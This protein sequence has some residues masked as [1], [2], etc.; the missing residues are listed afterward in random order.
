MFSLENVMLSIDSFPLK[1]HTILFTTAALLLSLFLVHYFSRTKIQL[2]FSNEKFQTLINS[3]P[4]LKSG[5]F[6]SF[7]PLAF[8]LGQCYLAGK[9]YEDDSK[10]SH[11]RESFPYPN[12]GKGSVEWITDK[13]KTTEFNS[14]IIAFIIPGLCSKSDAPYLQDLYA[15]L[16]NNNIRPVVFIPRLN[17]DK[18]LLPNS[19]FVNLLDDI[20]CGVQYVTTKHPNAKLIGIGHS[21]GANCIVNYLAAYN[22]EK[23]IVA[24]ISIANPYDFVG[25]CWRIRGTIIEKYIMSGIKELVCKNLDE[26]ARGCS[27]YKTSMQDIINTT[28]VKE[29]DDAFTSK[30]MGY[31]D[32]MDYYTNISSDKSVWDVQVPLMSINAE[33]DPFIYHKGVPISAHEKNDNL[34]FVVTRKGGHLGWIEGIF[35]LRRWYLPIVV[36]Y[37]HWI[38]KSI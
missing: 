25:S 30:A 20:H 5:K 27:L 13:T 10:L 24:G 4:S 23:T 3:S 36:D 31:K 8:G 2:L 1:A 17:D 11:T 19:S 34:L 18:F 22:K 29:F 26:I 32:A 6:Y 38:S 15:R 14:N 21:Y 28:K 12:G 16:I 35:R 33:D 7:P 37:I 9:K